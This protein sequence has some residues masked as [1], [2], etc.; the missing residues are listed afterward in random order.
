MSTSGG[1]F[2][3]DYKDGCIGVGIQIGLSTEWEIGNSL[4]VASVSVVVDGC[5]V[6]SADYA[7][8]RNSTTKLVKDITGNGNDLTVYGDVVGDKDAA[9]AAFV[10]EI[11]TQ[12]SQQSTI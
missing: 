3:F 9:V 12:I 10:D 8:A 7:I 6:A 11:K 5:I 1:T 4:K 2:E